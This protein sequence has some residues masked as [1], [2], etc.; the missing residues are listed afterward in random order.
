MSSSLVT[1]SWLNDRLHSADLKILDGTWYLPNSG[2]GDPQEQFSQSRI[3]GSQF[4][5]V[6][7]IADKSVNLPHM[8]PSE[9]AFAAAADALGISNDTQVVV[10][11]RSG[12]FSAARVWWTFKVFGHDSIA[13]LDGGLP[14]WLAAGYQT[15]ESPVSEDQLEAAVKAARQP[16][17]KLQYQAHLQREQ[18]RD[19]QEV[20]RNVESQREVVVDARG[21][22]RFEATAP[23]PRPGM[24]GG[25]IP[26][27]R[28]VPFD[29]LLT[30]GRLKSPDE[31]Q[32][33]FSTAGVDLQR[34]LVTSCGTGVTASVLALALHQLSPQP[35]VAVYDGSWS[36]W[37]S[38]QDTPIDTGKASD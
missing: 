34:P 30:N 4:F 7:N 31:I 36:E 11:D 33:V 20:L 2:K 12:L 6:D 15:D 1:P 10:Y 19:L 5:D 18:V 21:A 23:E 38:R 35:K 16:P 9:Q 25:H 26:H 28:N 17:A 8:L 37:G 3:P 13:V 14:A 29:T 32:G 22:G 24:R 27:S